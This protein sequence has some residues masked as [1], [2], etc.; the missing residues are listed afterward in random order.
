MRISVCF[1]ILF[2]AIGLMSCS[3]QKKLESDPPFSIE[4]PTVSYWAGGREESGTGMRFQARWNPAD[5]S[6]IDVDSLYFRGRILKLN[7]EETETG[8]LITGTY[9]TPSFANSDLIMHADS[10]REVGNQPP[11]PLPEGR[12]FPFELGP[13][14]AVMSY[15]VKS[16]EKK[17]YYK[18]SGVVEKTGRNYPERTKN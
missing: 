16:S 5:P 2:T 4:R 13:D 17:H 10:L 11:K 12:D 8:F 9:L 6:S 3:S 14:E 1:T 7:R 15:F 18:I